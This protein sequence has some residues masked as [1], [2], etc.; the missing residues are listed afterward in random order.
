MRTILSCAFG[1]ALMS[2]PVS[3]AVVDVTITGTLGGPD[4]FNSASAYDT[5]GNVWNGALVEGAAFTARYVY[6]TSL[7][8]RDNSVNSQP[9][10]ILSG[11]DE[12]P[13]GNPTTATLTIG[14]TTV[15]FAVTPDAHPADTRVLC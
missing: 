14:N 1:L 8:R 2:V 13:P 6:D 3:A 12:F 4:L 10:D 9:G 5:Y 15:A 11:N 7:G